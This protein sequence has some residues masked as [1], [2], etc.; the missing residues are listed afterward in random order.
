MI[1]TECEVNR[2]KVM[3]TVIFNVKTC[4][5]SFYRTLEHNVFKHCR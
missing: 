4:S 5:V 3:V 2:F 1:S